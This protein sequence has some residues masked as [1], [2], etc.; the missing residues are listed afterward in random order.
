M[1]GYKVDENQA[2][3][4]AAL[5]SCGCSVAI[6]AAAGGGFPDIVCGREGVTYLIEIK[7][8]G[9]SKS[10]RKLTGPQVDFH[11]NWRGQISIAETVDDALRIVGVMR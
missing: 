1:R 9:K 2:E 10:R 7:D 5:R 8:S 3:I 4:V 6:T 11:A